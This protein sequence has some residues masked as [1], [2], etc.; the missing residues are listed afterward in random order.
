MSSKKDGHTLGSIKHTLIDKANSRLVMT[1][2]IAAFLVVFS[3]IASKVLWQQAVYQARVIGKKQAAASQLE[4]NIAA[5]DKLKPSYDAFVNTAT[6]DIGGNSLGVGPKDGDNAKLILDALPSKYDFPEL[7]TNLE[8][9]V[10]DQGVRITGISGVDDEIAQSTNSY[11]P[12]PRPVDMPFQISVSSDYGRLQGLIR[13]LEHSI[14]PIKV[15]T[16]DVSGSHDKMTMNIS[17]VT[18]YQPA[19]SLTIRS[20]VVK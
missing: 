2:S 12:D 11:S 15:L 4:K 1:V 20:E 5:M 13:A 17:A 3:L 6:N 18:Y 7:T 16:L 14:R 9:L 19:K 10:N 8:N